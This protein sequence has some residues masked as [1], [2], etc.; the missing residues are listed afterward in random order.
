MKTKKAYILLLNEF[1]SHI[2]ALSGKTHVLL[3]NSLD[4]YMYR[5]SH[6]YSRKFAAET[7]RLGACKDGEYLPSC[8]TKCREKKAD[9]ERKWVKR[10]FPFAKKYKIFVLDKKLNAAERAFIICSRVL[11]TSARGIYDKRHHIAVRCYVRLRKFD[12]V[13][14]VIETHT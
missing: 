7:P 13:T 1:V 3:I 8:A 6:L 4:M 9:K 2:R 10:T 14:K 11:D 12:R 5:K